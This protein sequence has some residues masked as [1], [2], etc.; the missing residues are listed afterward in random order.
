M[1]QTNNIFYSSILGISKINGF[2]CLNYADERETLSHIGDQVCTFRFQQKPITIHYGADSIEK[3]AYLDW[4]KHCNKFLKNFYTSN[5]QFTEVITVP[6]TVKETDM[7]DF[8][9]MAMNTLKKWCSPSNNGSGLIV[10]N[11]DIINNLELLGLKKSDLTEILMKKEFQRDK[12]RLIVFNVVENIIF[13][14]RRGSDDLEEK[15]V[16]CID[17]VNLLSL[18]LKEELNQRGVKI[19]GLLVREKVVQTSMIQKSAIVVNILLFLQKYLVL[20]SHF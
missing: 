7:I 12:Q 15:I 5:G 14:I 8:W 20:Q 17:D 11:F 19:A 3:L 16:N 4:K 18:L 9:T 1:N 6:D 2:Y 10:T 13:V